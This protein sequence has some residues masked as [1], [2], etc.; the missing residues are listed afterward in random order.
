MIL[1]KQFESLQRIELDVTSQNITECVTSQNI[2]D[3][4]VTK[5]YRMCNVTVFHLSDILSGISVWNYKWRKYM[6]KRISLNRF[7]IC[8][9]LM[10]SLIVLLAHKNFNVLI[11]IRKINDLLICLQK[12]MK[13]F[14]AVSIS[15]V[16]DDTEVT[17]LKQL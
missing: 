10:P 15:T 5:Y 3:C 4:D 13:I 9:K 12:K 14:K 7:L 17:I 16:K 6:K 1:F 11:N 2:T 8:R